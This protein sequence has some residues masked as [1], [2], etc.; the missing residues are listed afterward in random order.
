MDSEDTE[1]VAT[2]GA[3]FLTEAGRVAGVLDRELLVGLVEPFVGVEGRD[4]L[5]RGGNE[6]FFGVLVRT[7]E[8]CF[9]E[10][11]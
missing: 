7:L 3:G 5:F 2:G 1:N 8:L 10:K 6:V 4:R 11:G 9:R